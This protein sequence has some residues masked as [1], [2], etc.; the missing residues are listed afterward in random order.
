MR[1]FICRYCH[2]EISGLPSRFEN[3][4]VNAANFPWRLVSHLAKAFLR[5]HRR[6]GDNGQR[7]EYKFTA[8]RLYPSGTVKI[9]L[10]L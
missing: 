4:T 7:D 1:V 6:H 2:D 8:G 9:G 10:H 3:R 5:S